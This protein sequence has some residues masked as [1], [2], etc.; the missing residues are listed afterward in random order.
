MTLQNG[1]QIWHELRRSGLEP[2]RKHELPGYDAELVAVLK[3]RLYPDATRSLEHEL[4][5]NPAPTE[6]FLEAFFSALKPFSQMLREV[7]AMFEAAGARRSDQNL[8]IAL[9]FD[10]AS[11]SLALTLHE[12]REI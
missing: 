10:K 3:E 7:L 8:R 6:A 4:S 11:E 9:D 5:A 12:F 1:L 2:A